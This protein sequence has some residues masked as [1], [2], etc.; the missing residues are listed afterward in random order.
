LQI[1]GVKRT[2]VRYV[3]RIDIPLPCHDLKEFFRTV[4]EVSPDLPQGLSGYFMQLQI[5]QADISA[6]AVINQMM[7]PSQIP[8]AISVILDID[9]FQEHS[10]MTGHTFWEILE[11]L[12]GKL[13]SVFEACITN[14]T[15][16]LIK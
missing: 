6:M 15:R 11:Q 16:E 4:P 3:N 13:D 2:A 9:I 8:D 7:V 10:L 14:Q 12:H 5:P 1:E